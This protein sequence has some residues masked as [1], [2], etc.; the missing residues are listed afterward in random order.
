MLAC[1]VEFADFVLYTF[2]NKKASLFVIL[3]PEF[4]TKCV[5]ESG[6]FY[7]VSVLPE[8]LGRWFTRGVVMLDSATDGRDNSQYN[9]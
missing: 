3:D 5:I 4:L 2:P 8:L 1:T 7:R 6:D 9:Y